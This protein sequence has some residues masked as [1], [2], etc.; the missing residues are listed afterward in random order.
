LAG[1]KLLFSLLEQIPN[2]SSL[3]QGGFI[4]ACGLRA[5][6]SIMA[7]RQWQKQIQM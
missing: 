3:R 7:G 4:L 2:K 1:Y 6:K 5:E